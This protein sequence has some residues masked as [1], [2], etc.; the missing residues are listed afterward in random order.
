MK[1]HFFVFLSIFGVITCFSQTG[2]V[3]KFD[4][5][6][7]KEIIIPFNYSEKQLLIKP[8]LKQVLF[9]SYRDQFTYWYK[10]VAKSNET[11]RFHISAINDSDSYAVYVYQFNQTDFCNKLYN[12]KVKPLFPLFYVGYGSNSMQSKEITLPVQKDTIY[13]ISVL[14]TSLNNCGH[15]L[16]LNYTTD[17]LNLQVF[18]M[19]CKKNVTTISLVPKPSKPLVIQKDSTTILK[20]KVEAI[21]APSVLV[22]KASKS[23]AVLKDSII[24]QKTKNSVATIDSIKLVVP[25]LESKSTST[26]M[27]CIVKDKKELKT[28]DA[29]LIVINDDTKDFISLANTSNGTW[30]LTLEK[31]KKYKIKSTSFG[32][33]DL[34]MYTNLSNGDTIEVLMEPLKVGDNFIMKSIYFHPNTYALRKESTNELQT[35]LHYL[36]NNPSVTIE[37]QGHTNGD[38]KIYKNK[39]YGELS[40]EWNFK[41][42]SKEL[43]LKRAESIKKY[44]INNSVSPERLIPKGE[45]GSKPIVEN[46]ETMEEGQKNI[47]VE[48]VILAN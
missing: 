22:S 41:G 3:E 25:N 20:K 8:Q 14:N 46:P 10:I 30:E 48:V 29:Q 36:M 12:H 7:S 37:I 44:L 5:T 26:L 34:E 23:V 27:K 11:L 17:T 47:R 43:S 32:Y 1:Y 4:C 42:S 15:N 19:P 16:K 13:Y 21:I 33:K 45:G 28:I 35:L 40:E 6:Y 31:D 38:N 2:E 39:A 18:H 9:Y 24:N